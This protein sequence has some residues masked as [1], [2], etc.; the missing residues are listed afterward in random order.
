MF[1]NLSPGAIGI[2]SYSL[3]QSLELARQTGFEGID[4]NIK[5]AAELAEKHGADYV[6]GLFTDAGIRPGAWGLPVAWREDS[7]KDDLKVLP[8]L[9]A[10]GQAI[11]ALRTATWCPP[12]SDTMP[13]AEN[14]QWHV[15]RYGPIAEALAPYGVRFGIEF[16]GPQTLRP[17]DKHAFIYTMEGMLE[18]IRALDTDNVGLLLDAWH[19]YTS[20]G[21][22]DDLDKITN[23]DVVVV[24]V[25]DAPEG[26][27]MATYND[28]DRRLPMETEVMDLPGFMRKLAAMGYDGPVTP[29]PFSARLNSMDDPLEAAKETARYMD[30]MW[31]ASGLG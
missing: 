28:H 21:S 26:L 27:T 13:F 22:L 31:A 29:E 12:S 17:A 30:R 15:D 25:N 7:W 8:E 19:L 5:E 20:G 6:R 9:A 23:A 14:F 11:G 4:F 18:L 24:H 3:Q 16:I 2:R 10:V 1:R